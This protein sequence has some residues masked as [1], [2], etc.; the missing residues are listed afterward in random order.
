[1]NETAFDNTETKGSIVEYINSS[2]LDEAKRRIR[3]IIE[4]F[5]KV[6][7]CFSGGKDSL[8]VLHLVEEVRHSM[9]IYD[10]LDVIFRDE[11]LIPDD[12]IDFVQSYYHMK[13]RFRMHYYAVPLLSEKFIL[14]KTYEYIQWDPKRK[15]IREKP[16][17][18]IKDAGGQVFSQHTMDEFI[19]SN[20]AGKL[21][22]VNGI[23]ADE[24]LVR[25]RSVV[26]K[27]NEC[28]VAASSHPRVKLCKPIYDWSEKDIFKYFYD[29]D[30]KYCPIYNKQVWNNQGLRVS[31]PLH[32]ESA[33]RFYQIRTLY[34]T[35]Y[36]QLVDVFPEMIVQER[37]WDEYDRYAV[38]YKYE[39]SWDGLAQ[40]IKENIT[41][42]SM[43]KLAMK[44]VA[45]ARLYRE[46][47]MAR[48]QYLDNFGG[49]PILYVF[50]A[51]INGQFERTIQPHKTP[52]KTEIEYERGA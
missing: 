10:P 27:K 50:K 52:S 13:D 40:Y 1:M 43:F 5:D 31:T 9:G 11:E 25:L 20:H 19:A 2:V 36:Q 15:W 35:F 26:N 4:T 45:D 39:K 28:F 7:V 14:G 46:N 42:P 16:D 32:A 3:H 30:I 18:A 6:L 44:R 48:G 12:V 41:N 37:Y 33:K 38:I 21:A 24:S 51:I 29:N 22:F 8:V 34:P 49:Y 47:N 17:F 23:R